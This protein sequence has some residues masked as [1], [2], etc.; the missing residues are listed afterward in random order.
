MTPKEMYRAMADNRDEGLL[1]LPSDDPAAFTR[2][3]RRCRGG[4]HPFEICRGGN[5]T[6]ISLHVLERG[7]GWQ[8]RLAGFSAVRA[9]ETAR[10]AI[11]LSE[12]G[13]PFMLEFPEEMLRMLSGEDFLGIV[14]EDVPV[15]YNH[16]DFPKE[17]RIHSF[18]HLYVIEDTCELLPGS[19]T[20]Y[21][22]DE[23]VPSGDPAGPE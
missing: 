5:R 23:L 22:L 11:A 6:H 10:M 21:P 17:D 14:P 20:W 3:Y 8:L 16:G 2:W 18:I 15:G 4:G 9:V 1:D 13:V 12:H 7:D 19:I